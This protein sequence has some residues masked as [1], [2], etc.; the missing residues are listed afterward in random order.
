[1]G[2]RTDGGLRGVGTRSLTAPPCAFHR[3]ADRLGFPH[4]VVTAQLTLRT[5]EC[6]RTSPNSGQ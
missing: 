1:M 5:H 6:V 2:A 4:A 3:A